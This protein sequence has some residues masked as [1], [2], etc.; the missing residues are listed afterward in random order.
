M[1]PVTYTQITFYFLQSDLWDP[2]SAYPAMAAESLHRWGARQE[3]AGTHPAGTAERPAAPDRHGEAFPR[4]RR[5]HRQGQAA[6]RPAG[7]RGE[8]AVPRHS[9]CFMLLLC[10]TCWLSGM[11]LETQKETYFI[12]L[13]VN[14]GDSD[15]TDL[16]IFC[17]SCSHP[18]NP[19]VALRH[20]ERCYA[21]VK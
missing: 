8:L 6:G 16:Q 7:W 18:V 10:G 1:T 15:D 4:T 14:E 13:Q 12:Y 3:A 11:S 2:A 5:H 21:K 9:G 19:K 17:V 20:M